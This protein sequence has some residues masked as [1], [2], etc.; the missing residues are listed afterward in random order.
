MLTS[1]KMNPTMSTTNVQLTVVPLNAGAKN[2][3]LIS[4]ESEIEV[5]INKQTKTKTKTKIENDVPLEK[6]LDQ[7]EKE[8]AVTR[9]HIPAPLG[10]GR[11]MMKAPTVLSPTLVSVAIYGAR[12]E[13]AP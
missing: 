1:Q 11:W 13:A 7:T 10:F 3:Y 8:L 5:Q 9:D 12:S 4:F 6:K 2:Y